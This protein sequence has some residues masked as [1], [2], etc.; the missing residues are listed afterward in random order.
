[1]AIG[2]GRDYFGHIAVDF[3]CLVDHDT[4]MMAGVDDKIPLD[5]VLGENNDDED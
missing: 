1:M 5:L 3:D 2:N 4:G